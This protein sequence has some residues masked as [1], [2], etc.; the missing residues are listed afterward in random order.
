MILSCFSGWAIVIP[1]V[2]YDFLLLKAIWPTTL[3][4]LYHSIIWA[5]W[6]RRTDGKVDA[7]HLR[8]EIFK[9]M[10]AML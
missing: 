7:A 2:D 10:A 4:K 5:N 8:S 1:N 9:G 6:S 3:E